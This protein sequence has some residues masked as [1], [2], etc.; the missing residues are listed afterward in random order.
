MFQGNA[1]YEFR[2]VLFKMLI[3]GPSYTKLVMVISKE[4]RVRQLRR[5]FNRISFETF[6]RTYHF[7]IRWMIPDRGKDGW[8]GGLPELFGEYPELAHEY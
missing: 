4:P 1:I 3:A 7:S 2:K 8:T 6:E 5:P